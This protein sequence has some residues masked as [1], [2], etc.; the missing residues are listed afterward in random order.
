MNIIRI[1]LADGRTDSWGT[2]GGETD[3]EIEELQADPDVIS[4]EVDWDVPE[5]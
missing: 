5:D 3:A 1:V 2:Y 4:I